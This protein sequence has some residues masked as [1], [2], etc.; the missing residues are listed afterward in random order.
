MF[1][2][3]R[4]RNIALFALIVLVVSVAAWQP[5]KTYAAGGGTA[6]WSDGGYANRY[7]S[8]YYYVTGAP[9]NMCGEVHLVR[10]GVPQIIGMGWICTDGSGNATKGPWTP[11]SDETAQSIYT[12]WADGSRTTGGDFHINDVTDP[13]ITT[14]QNG[15]ISIPIPT[16][17]NGT[18]SDAQWGTGFNFSYGGWSYVYARFYDVTS[19]KY[20]DGSSYNSVGTVS[21]YGTVSPPSGGYNIT[22]SVPAPRSDAHNNTDTY[23]WCVY[24]ADKFYPAFACIYFYGPR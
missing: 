10:N 6:R 7:T 24:T 1:S 18:A 14:Y 23:K 21:W 13:T 16:A 11:T 12:Q 2:V 19:G 20:Y 4:T 15:G 17:F 22:W 9:P 5:H 3:R 8:Y